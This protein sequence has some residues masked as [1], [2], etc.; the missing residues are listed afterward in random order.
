MLIGLENPEASG[1]IDSL[2][3]SCWYANSIRVLANG[4]DLQGEALHWPAQFGSQHRRRS[5]LHQA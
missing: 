5:H 2:G 3:P 4:T 1:A